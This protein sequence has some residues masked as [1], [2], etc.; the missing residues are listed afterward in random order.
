MSNPGTSA[1]GILSKAWIISANHGRALLPVA[2]TLNAGDKFG[3]KL[4][5][6]QG[7]P[8][9]I[10][11]TQVYN[12]ADFSFDIYE[13][14]IPVLYA[15]LYDLD[16]ASSKFVVRPELL[17]Q[18]KFTLLVVQYHAQTGKVFQAKLLEQCHLSDASESSARSSD[19]KVSFKGTA[20]RMTKTKGLGIWYSRVVQP[21]PKFV[22]AD[23]VSF[24]GSSAT[25]AKTPYSVALPGVGGTTENCICAMKNRVR[26]DSGFTVSG[27]SFS[28]STT[29]S[30][31]DVWDV[32]TPY[33]DSI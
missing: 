1:Q 2:D 13:T 23:D 8:A 20:T 29:P 11:N 14:D 15:L 24:V 25:L 31:Y 33:D 16:P 32:F 28:V 12:G 30:T 7:N 22:T 21:A 4:I 19:L 18:C 27:A 9:P 17:Y 5:D 3:T 26:Q 10:L 6:E